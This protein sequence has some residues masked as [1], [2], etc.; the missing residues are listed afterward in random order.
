MTKQCNHFWILELANGPDSSAECRH[1]GVSNSFHNSGDLAIYRSG[2][3]SDAVAAA[4]GWKDVRPTDH[5]LADE[6]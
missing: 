2:A 6:L 3:N 4:G 5:V 1:C